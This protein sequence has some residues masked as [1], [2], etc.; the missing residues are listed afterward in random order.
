MRTLCYLAATAEKGTERRIRPVSISSNAQRLVDISGQ[1]HDD[2][3]LRRG[4]VVLIFTLTDYRP[5]DQEN[6]FLWTVVGNREDIGFIYVI[7]FGNKEQVLKA[8]QIK[9]AAYTVGGFFRYL[10]QIIFRRD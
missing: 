4:S 3:K 9:Y 7:P 5:C 1:A 2:E 6:R 10:H 8:A